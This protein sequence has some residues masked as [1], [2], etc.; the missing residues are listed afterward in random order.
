[1]AWSRGRNACYRRLL[2]A[3]TEDPAEITPRLASLGP[4]AGLDEA[5]WQALLAEALGELSGTGGAD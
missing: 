2:L 3:Q 4:E 1:M 5:T